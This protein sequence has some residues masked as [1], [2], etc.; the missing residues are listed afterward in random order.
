MKTKGTHTLNSRGEKVID[1]LS[2]INQQRLG[3]VAL[4][5]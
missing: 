4:K 3:N 2:V 1:W 5:F